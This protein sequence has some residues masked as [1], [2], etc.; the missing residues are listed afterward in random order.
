[1]CSSFMIDLRKVDIFAAAS[2][3]FTSNL[4]SS[5]RYASMRLGSMQMSVCEERNQ[6]RILNIEC[7]FDPN[8]QVLQ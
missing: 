6:V 1:M 4:A 3:S 5:S 2:E 8:L 7:L